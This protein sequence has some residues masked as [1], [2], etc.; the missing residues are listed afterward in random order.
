MKNILSKVLLLCGA[1]V[2][3]F[4]PACS[5]IE[6]ESKDY[7]FEEDYFK[8]Y[9]DANAALQG[10]YAGLQQL[11][12]PMFV[13]GE[14]RADLVKP[15]PGVSEEVLQ[16]FEHRISPNNRYTDWSPYYDLIN[17]TNWVLKNLPTVENSPFFTKTTQN[18]YRGE[19]LFLRSLAYF[20]L[21]RNFGDV[22]LVLQPTTSIEQNVNY[23]A[24][25]QR[26]V[27]DTIVANLDKA[28]KIVTVSITEINNSLTPQTNNTYT[29]TRGVIA[30]V[31]A[32]KAEVLLW[33]HA[34]YTNNSIDDLKRA[35]DAIQLVYDNSGSYSL[36]NNFNNGNWFN[37]FRNTYQNLESIMEIP[38]QFNSRETNN[39]QELTSRRAEEGG[40]GMLIP[41]D[42]V[43]SYFKNTQNTTGFKRD[44]WRGFGSS[45]D[46]INPT[47]YEIW[48]YIGQDR[49]TRN[50]VTTETATQPLVY[51][52]NPTGR[53]KPFE[54]DAKW[55]ISR[56]GNLQLLRAEVRNRLGDRAT[57]VTLL[58]GTRN[59][60]QL[61]NYPGI[62]ATSTQDAIEEAILR[63]KA[64]ETA[65]EGHRWYD[66]LRVAYR[67]N[68]NQWL[69]DKVTARITNPTKKAEVAAR[70][71]N[72]KNWFLPYNT[73]E[74]ALNPALV[75]K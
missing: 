27:L 31:N 60:A 63:E 47:E 10:A 25:P 71:A 42:V 59:R 21:V 58:N 23:A 73:N 67:R 65:F 7:V 1:S 13:L 30:S 14:A 40:K 36:S 61:G 35:D 4:L 16:V 19:M 66:L 5:F 6:P 26:V 9:H 72:R 2:I 53:E 12:D 41:S 8:N 68:N 44:L 20:N 3:T 69:I 48:K 28:S 33:R 51:T 24:V 29:K 56:M 18:Q 74:L 37:I 54:G 15:G 62:S 11:V 45:Y 70:L 75:Q 64:M 39:L 46:S 50:R 49:I 34:L 17:R 38:F 55:Y 52:V 43:M 32:L 57:A 22:P